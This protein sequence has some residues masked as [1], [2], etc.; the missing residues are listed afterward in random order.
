MKPLV[1]LTLLSIFSFNL[2]AAGNV[3]SK[4]EFVRVDKSGK[5]YIKFTAALAGSKP[6]CTTSGHSNSL[7]FRLSD[8]GGPGILSMALAAK[9]TGAKVK[10]YGTGACGIY[11]VMEDWNYGLI[12]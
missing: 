12:K 2:L 10:A 9:A 1:F 8:V 7:A 5:G 4:V 6:S 3:N 11:G